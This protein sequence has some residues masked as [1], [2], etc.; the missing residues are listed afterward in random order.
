[1]VITV[2]SDVISN[3]E[4]SSLHTLCSL[5]SVHHL[6]DLPI[7]PLI[8]PPITHPWPYLWPCPKPYPRTCSW[9]QLWLQLWPC[10][11]PLPMIPKWEVRWLR[12][13]T[14]WY[15]S[16]GQSTKSFERSDAC[17]LDTSQFTIL[18]FWKCIDPG[19]FDAINTWST[20]IHSHST[21]AVY[22]WRATDMIS[23]RRCGNVARI[24]WGY[25]CGPT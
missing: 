21:T 9:P 8:T 18:S 6:L 15:V 12:Q 20:H 14:Q 10:P 5:W 7:T 19:L 16:L 1:M 3:T 23:H 13:P 24:R 11:W 22:T 25:D 17:T 2:V 4:I